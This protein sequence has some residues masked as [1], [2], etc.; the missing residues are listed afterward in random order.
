MK[1][2]LQAAAF[3]TLM[4]APAT[5]QSFN[6]G[7]ALFESCSKQSQAY[8]GGYIIGVFDAA[9]PVLNTGAD[10]DGF[11]F[12]APIEVTQG[13]ITDIVVN[14]LRANPQFR[15]FNAASLTLSALSKAYPCR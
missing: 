5:A 15:H 3:L 9:V 2:F 10:V 12:C 11:K 4:A 8:C 14:Y 1:Y 6:S 7:N 13:Q